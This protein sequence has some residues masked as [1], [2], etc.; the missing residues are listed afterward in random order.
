VIE[1]GE[2]F[3]VTSFAM[4]LYINGLIRLAGTHLY[5]KLK[6]N[7]NKNKNKRRRVFYNTKCPTLVKHNLNDVHISS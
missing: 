6:K 5:L 1:I 4:F 2:L 7:N 3:F